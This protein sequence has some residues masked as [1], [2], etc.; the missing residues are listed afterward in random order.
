MCYNCG[1]FGTASP[2]LPSMASRRLVLLTPSE[3]VRP[4]RL[5]RASRG[6]GRSVPPPSLSTFNFGSEVTKT[7]RLKV[8]GNSGP[9]IPTRSGLLT[10]YSSTFQPLLLSMFLHSS[11]I[12]FPCHTS[13][14]SSAN[15]NHCHTSKAASRKSFACHTSN[16]RGGCALPFAQPHRFFASPLVTRHSSL[17]PSFSHSC[18]LFCTFLHP[19]KAQLFC[20]HA[21]P[22]SFTKTPGGGDAPI[23]YFLFPPTSGV[24]S[25]P[26]YFLPSET[27][28]APP[29]E[30]LRSFP[31]RDNAAA[32]APAL[33]VF[34]LSGC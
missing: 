3:S 15:S 14:K 6:P 22:D 2:S 21:I 19:A 1:C 7:P 13:E 31:T 5:P 4:P 34:R 28:S 29:Q 11:P 24:T 12:S 25:L 23:P 30:H 8:P 32:A 26:P 16:P 17:C 33:S 18:A 20:F 27:A 10:S 9:E